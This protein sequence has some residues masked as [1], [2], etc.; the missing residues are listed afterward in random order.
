MMAAKVCSAVWVLCRT[1]CVR[2]VALCKAHARVMPDDVSAH[3]ECDMIIL[4][5]GLCA[6]VMCGVLGTVHVAYMIE[7]SEDLCVYCVCR[8]LYVCMH[9]TH[10]VQVCV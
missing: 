6:R 1:R 9:S 8:V 7:G 2:C 3:I 4:V 5:L 10:T